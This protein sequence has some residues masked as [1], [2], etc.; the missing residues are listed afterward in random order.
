MLDVM[1]TDDFRMA[2]WRLNEGPRTTYGDAYASSPVAELVASGDCA[3]VACVDAQKW[4]K[5]VC[6]GDTPAQY[7]TVRTVHRNDRGVVALEFRFDASSFSSRYRRIYNM[8]VGLCR[9]Q[10]ATIDEI[11]KVLDYVVVLKDA[12]KRHSTVSEE[13]IGLSAG[14]YNTQRERWEFDVED[15]RHGGEDERRLTGLVCRKAYQLFSSELNDFATEKGI[16]Q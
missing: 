5:A 2:A 16:V 10:V 14:L 12:D 8:V 6:I 9:H 13:T 11:R 7:E 1:T 4:L 3:N 15:I